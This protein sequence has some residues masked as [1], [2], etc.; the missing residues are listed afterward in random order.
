MKRKLTGPILALLMLCFGTFLSYGVHFNCFG[1]E[2]ETMMAFFGIDE[3]KQGMILTVQSIGGIIVTILLGLYGERMNKIHGLA[4]GLGLMG[5]ASVLIGTIPLYCDVNTGYGLMLA[6]SLLAG[7]GSITV[8]CLMNGVISDVY[9]DKK[10]TFL[11]YVHASYG[12]GA[13]LAPSFVSLLASPDAPASFA[14]PYLVLGIVAVIITAVL[15]LN[16]RRVKPQTPYRDMT[17]LKQ[18]AMGN[19]A[20]VFKDGRAWLILLS[21][22][23]YLCFQTGISAWMPQYAMRELRFSYSDA[24][25]LSTLYFLGALVMRLISPFIYKKLSVQTFFV[26]TV[27]ASAALFVVFLLTSGSLWMARGLILAIGFLQGASVPSLVILCC[28]LFPERSASASSVI[29]LSVS[30]AALIAP[31]VM[32]AVINASGYLTALILILV[33]L[34]LSVPVLLLATWHRK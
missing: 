13:V 7:L 3:T 10:S 21:C 28:D 20:E 34:I 30:L 26:V 11:P 6:F 12:V 33:C 2:A 8:D 24:A 16:A 23:L 27:S 25:L 31:S 1:T 22:F 19:P 29:V 32:G 5:V 17:A 15:F 9:P 18:R 14:M 4:L